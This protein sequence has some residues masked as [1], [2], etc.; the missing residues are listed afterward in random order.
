[1]DQLS[2]HGQGYALF[3][4][5]CIVYIT[6]PVILYAC[7][8]IVNLFFAGAEVH[9]VDDDHSAEIAN[10]RDDIG[11]TR[12]V[13]EDTKKKDLVHGTRDA[14]DSIPPMV[15][16]EIQNRVLVKNAQRAAFREELRIIRGLPPEYVHSAG[17]DMGNRP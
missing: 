16:S 1:M 13:I 14:G 5:L 6:A 10:V 11:N 15:H 4:T 7:Q 3:V 9:Y 8:G 2:V 17:C 12:A